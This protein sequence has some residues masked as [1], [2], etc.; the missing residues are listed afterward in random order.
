MNAMMIRSIVLV[1][2]CFLAATCGGQASCQNERR[3]AEILKFAKAKGLPT[4]S[5]NVTSLPELRDNF[6]SLRQKAPEASLLAAVCFY[7]LRRERYGF[8][9]NEVSSVTVDV[10]DGD[11]EWY[12]AS[13]SG[14][15]YALK[16]FQDATKEFDRMMM[17]F[18]ADVDSPETAVA[19]FDLYAGVVY[20]AACRSTIISDDLKLISV[21][22]A[23]F[24]LR[25]P[26]ARRD[27]EFRKWWTS[28][29]L[30]HPALHPPE[31][32][33]NADNYTISYFTYENGRALERTL[34]MD[35]QGRITGESKF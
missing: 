32:R 12:V 8:S 15:A 10:D 35:R 7:S 2:M 21:A 33:K 24:R 19:N 27:Q 13:S 31:A 9:G 34:S 30:K 20:G 11:V 1:G 28:E 4:D 26:L 17:D 22:A 16:G 25:F 14:E 6:I 3:T 23:D 5:L 29:R 18:H